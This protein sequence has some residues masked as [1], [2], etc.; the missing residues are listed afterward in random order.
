MQALPAKSGRGKGK[1]QQM[2]ELRIV[3]AKYEMTEDLDIKE[4]AKL[5][6]ADLKTKFPGVKASVR[7]ERYSMGQAI[8]VDILSGLQPLHQTEPPKRPSVYGAQLRGQIAELLDEYNY[9]NSDMM[10]DYYD[11]RF[12]S[13]VS[14]VRNERD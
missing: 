11:V 7:I 1:T 9:D 6:R 14:L 12:A 10:E 5:V 13:R 4:I 2:R 8:N 3:G